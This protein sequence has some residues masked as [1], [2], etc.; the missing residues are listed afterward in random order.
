M[1]II[2]HVHVTAVVHCLSDTIPLQ[3]VISRGQ[4]SNIQTGKIVNQRC[5]SAVNDHREYSNCFPYSVEQL[6]TF[7]FIVFPTEAPNGHREIFFYYFRV[8]H[9]I[10]D[11]DMIISDP[12][13]PL[14]IIS[15][16]DVIPWRS[17][18]HVRGRDAMSDPEIIEK[19]SPLSLR[20]FRTFPLDVGRSINLACH[21]YPV[22]SV[23]LFRSCVWTKS[24][25]TL[26]RCKHSAR[27]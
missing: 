22:W 2:C 9:S 17:K 1:I 16:S 13:I 12:E 4:S 10:S 25:I 6:V 23:R 19:N 11:T 5:L 18:L 20:G 14:D 24:L 3:A 7:H 15:G 27:A 8:R 21:R 26:T